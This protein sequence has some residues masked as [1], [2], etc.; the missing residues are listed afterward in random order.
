MRER[1]R[2]RANM[3]TTEINI[4]R[5]IIDKNG[6]TLQL[7]QLQQQIQSDLLCIFHR[8]PVMVLDSRV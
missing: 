3:R 6:L 2:H 7:S 1:E 4:L 8:F 5:K